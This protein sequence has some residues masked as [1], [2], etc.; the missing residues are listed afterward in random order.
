MFVWQISLG[1]LED[2]KLPTP[3][4]DMLSIIAEKGQE[5]AHIFEIL[6]KESHW[7]L[8]LDSEQHSDWSEEYMLITASVLK[9][10]K[11]FTSPTLTSL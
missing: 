9:V 5:S 10:R 1:L 4:L 2:K 11:V 7:S 8:R 3:K 6:P